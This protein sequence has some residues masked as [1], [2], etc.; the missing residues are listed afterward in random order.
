MLSIFPTI[1]TTTSSVSAP[2]TRTSQPIVTGTTVIGIKYADGVM[3]AADTLASYGS[4]A[5]YNDVRRLQ[6]VGKNTL[7]GASGEISDFQA[8]MEILDG[9]TR[10]DINQDDGYSRTPMEV[11]NYLRTVMYQRRN[12]GNPLWNQ[13]L[14]AGFRE[15]KPFLGYVDLI[16]T[17]YEENFIATGFGAYLAIPLIRERWHADISE[18]EARTLLEDCLRVMFYRDCRASSRIQIAK[19]TAAGTLISEPYQLTSDWETATYDARHAT[20]GMDGSSW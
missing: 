19:A 4:L 15:Q 11:H 6:S 1:T 12:K 2:T 16:G 20:A 9:M 14:V 17:A 18:S 3:L 7:I 13:L 5:R 8:I 10:E